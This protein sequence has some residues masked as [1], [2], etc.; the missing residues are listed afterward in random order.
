MSAPLARFALLGDLL[1]HRSAI[2]FRR[3]V[4][5]LVAIL[6]CPVAVFAQQAAAVPAIAAI[7]KP[8][9]VSNA[10]DLE[11]F[12]DGVL[13]V[14]LESKHIAG[15][16]VAVV[17][18]DKLVFSKG[19]GYA[20]IDVRRKVD[21][22]K[23]LF[24]V[25]SITKLFTWTA[26][27]QLHEEGKLDL[28]ADVNKYLK[29]VQIPATFEQP[30][31]L[32]SLMTH[33]PGF[34]DSVIGLFSHNFEDVHRPLAEVLD[35]QMPKRVRPPGVVPAYSNQG[36]ALAGLA[37]ACVSG[38]P[39]ED[40]VELR[41]LQPLGMRHT[42][43]R[44]PRADELPADMSKGYQWTGGWLK[45][46][47]NIYAP[48]AP[49]G[50]MRT[51]AADIAKFMLAHLHD[52]QL[53]QA[54][55]LKPETARLMHSPAFRSDPKTSA[56]CYGF[57]EREL[58]GQRLI[59]HGGDWDGYHSSL[60]LIPDRHVG[61]FVSYNTD[62][63]DERDVLL[64]AFMR[65]YFPVAD[66]PLVQVSSDARE[67]TKRLAGQ[68][69]DTRYSHT[70]FTKLSAALGGYRVAAND[71]GTLTISTGTRS[72]RF[73]E[74]QPLVFREVDGPREFVFTEGKSGK[75]EYLF[76]ADLA[77][78]SAVPK[79]WYE[80]EDTQTGLLGG[81]AAVFASALLFWP[82]LAFTVRGGNSAG[83]LRN[84][85]SA[86]LSCLGWLFALASI[87]FLVALGSIV[88]DPDFIAYGL[89][90]SLKLLLASP[91]IIAVLAALTMLGVLIAWNNRYWRLS[92][93]VHYTLV[94][95]AGVVFVAWLYYWNFLTFG[96]QGLL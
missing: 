43:V 91:P 88:A 54:H 2:I 27:M 75:I 26:I 25:A 38:M 17:M 87:G 65:R 55:I 44:Q 70:T 58:N 5:T 63:G 21:P 84:R 32:T 89:T 56:M 79:H 12:F 61:L 7:G 83:I 80:T 40:Y 50:C 53:G 23:T 10:A 94:G 13:L 82:A 6:L 76:P 35:E 78:V 90:P 68:Y 95:L 15:A 11:A 1:M 73:V 14:Q 19:Y 49:A 71:D 18:G 51:T 59:G 16:V 86:L 39:W 64:S 92:G 20:D 8:A 3:F 62:L 85:R 31:T 28:G 77:A 72:H 48:L 33:T 69:A 66:P 36:T 9:D 60:Q 29:G 52:G 22:E 47:S 57:W 37:V 24:C 4:L 81:C 74:V 41:I 67:R 34:E 96:F 93:R 45:A 42:L 30:V 46:H